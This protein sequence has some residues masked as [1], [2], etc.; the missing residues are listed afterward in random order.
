MAIE[1]TLQAKVIKWLKDNDF[2]VIKTSAITGVPCG[3]PDL[4]ALK[5]GYYVALEIKASKN[6][7]K[8]PLQQYTIDLLA[9]DGYAW[10]VY[11]ENWQSIKAEL[12]DVFA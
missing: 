2:Y 5:N 3:C 9:K 10:F 8:Q 6:A 11:P 7:H 4:I 12:E 1:S